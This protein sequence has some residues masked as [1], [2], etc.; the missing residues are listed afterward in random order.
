MSAPFDLSETDRLLCTT[1]AVRR[2]LDLERPVERER[3]LEC[4]RLAQQAPTASNTQTW[5][6]LVVSD[7]GLRGEIAAVYRSIA[8]AALPQARRSYVHDAQ[9]QRVYDSAE[10]LAEHLHRVPVLVLPC[11]A[12]PEEPANHAAAAALYGSIFPA[13]WSFQLALRSRGL[14]STLTTLHLY[15]EAEVAKLLGIP[16][17]VR[18]V[19]LLPVAYTVGTQFRAARRPPPESIVHWNRWD[20]GVSSALPSGRTA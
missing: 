12:A 17:D 15:R 5:R 7:A 11:V 4:V 20:A 9:T 16:D 13:V 18:Q 2:R 19:G 14:G 10:W 1:R 3:I 8:H 6:W